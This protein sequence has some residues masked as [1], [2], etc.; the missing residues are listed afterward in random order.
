MW[1]DLT[2]E[3]TDSMSSPFW[4]PGSSGDIIA[5]V[6]CTETGVSSKTTT[7]AFSLAWIRPKSSMAR[8]NFWFLLHSTASQVGQGCAFRRRE[9]QTHTRTQLPFCSDRPFPLSCGNL[10]CPPR[11]ITR[12]TLECLS[13]SQHKKQLFA[14][15]DWKSSIFFFPVAWAHSSP[16][17]IHAIQTLCSSDQGVRFLCCFFQKIYFS[18][19]QIV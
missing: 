2:Q 15:R 14:F 12:R 10:T 5:S 9:L 17:T 18:C 1:L 7:G 4:R 19:H 6:P 13:Q 11:T 8:T 3:I 16:R